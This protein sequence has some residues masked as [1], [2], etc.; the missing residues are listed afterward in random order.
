[1][2]KAHLQLYEI[3]YL[4]DILL[5]TKAYRFYSEINIKSTDQKHFLKNA[6]HS[7]K[8]GFSSIFHQ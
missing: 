1:M 8:F 3:T 2:F 6:I 7:L 5:F 4:I